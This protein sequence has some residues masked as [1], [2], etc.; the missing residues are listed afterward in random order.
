MVMQLGSVIRAMVGALCLAIAAAP[1][2]AVAAEEAPLISAA[3]LAKR[4]EATGKPMLLDVRTPEEFAQGHLPGAVNIPLDD[5]AK[6]VGEVKSAAPQEVVV[7][8]QRGGRARKG[9]EV[10]AKAGVPGIL[11]LD[12]G[13]SAWVEAGQPVTKPPTAP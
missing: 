9:E 5:L 8:C 3:D 7:Y 13:M 11:H 6:R 2:A 4:V 1:A 10:L 12:G